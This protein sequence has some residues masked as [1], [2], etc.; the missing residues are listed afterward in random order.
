MEYKITKIPQAASAHGRH[1]R[2]LFFI[3]CRSYL[4][5]LSDFGHIVLSHAAGLPIVRGERCDGGGH[6][7]GIEMGRKSVLCPCE[8][9]DVLRSRANI[10][11]DVIIEN[12]FDVIIVIT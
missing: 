12:C 9:E 11:H 8:A 3:P 4:T 7:E 6:G 5:Q 1:D 2:S 10:S